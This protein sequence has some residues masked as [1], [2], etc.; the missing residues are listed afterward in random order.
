MAFRHDEEGGSECSGGTEYGADV[1]RIGDAIKAD[2]E[3]A[4]G[5]LAA[6]GVKICTGQWLGGECH[7]LMARTA[8]YDVVNGVA[9]DRLDR[10]P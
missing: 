1:L 5:S 8:A 10:Q 7:A 2:G 6:E 4:L 3:G 9:G